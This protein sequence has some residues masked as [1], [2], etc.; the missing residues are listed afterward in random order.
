[1]LDKFKIELLRLINSEDSHIASSDNPSILLA[2]S[3]GID[4]MC[5]LNL[6]YECG[7]R[8]FGVATVNFSLRGDQSDLDEELVER[9]C[10]NYNIP[11]YSKRFDTKK[12]SSSCGISTQMAAREL[13]YRWFNELLKC[14]NYSY[15]SIAHNLNDSIE[16]FF[17]NAVRGTGLK[18]LG[19]IRKK[20]G[21]IIRP[22]LIFTR[23][24]IV[25]YVNER[26]VH[27]RDD[28]SNFEC[29]YSRNRIRN[30]VFP[31]LEQINPSFLRT[32]ERE[33]EVIQSAQL[34]IEDLFVKKREELLESNPTRISINRLKADVGSKYWLYMILDE[35][36]FNSSQCDKIWDSLDGQP[37]LEF[38]S[39]SSI[40]IR[41][42]EYL[43]IVNRGKGIEFS[44]FCKISLESLWDYQREKRVFE[45]DIFSIK[46]EI[47]ERPE[48][49]IF[50]R[51]V[52]IGS[53]NLPDLFE[54]KIY[55]VNE[56]LLYVD[57]SLIKWPIV[58]RKWR[59]GDRFTPLGMNGRKKISDYLVDIKMSKFAK[60]HQLVI[61]SN[62][63][64]IALVG[65]RLDSKYRVTPSTKNIL[66]IEVTI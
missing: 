12:Y 10:I 66:V 57:S 24:Q 44:Q 58:I 9:W 42:R 46:L 52:K 34:I 30:R 21:N 23:E 13:R 15:I 5:M 37:G 54:N 53:E 6:F 43:L 39:E 48:D 51:R 49:L 62:G 16:T 60:E 36:G 59:D 61:E 7:Y 19:G 31:E 11:F 50:N 29:H 26:G 56:S 25:D 55:R 22:L 38:H 3:G 28:Q 4:S 35:F 18:G 41:D 20:S 40:L 27:F 8:N 1:M 63:E 2:V 65:Q 32:M 33:I 17:I 45:I 64:I 14:H 47:K